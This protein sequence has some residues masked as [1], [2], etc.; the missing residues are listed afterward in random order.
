MV[1]SILTTFRHKSR[2]V[3]YMKFI[4]LNRVC[5]LVAVLLKF[6]FHNS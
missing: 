3:L 1:C 6:E 5:Y 2:E 4:I